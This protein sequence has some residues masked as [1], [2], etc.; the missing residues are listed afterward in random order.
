MNAEVCQTCAQNSIS[1]LP[2][3][4]FYCKPIE[5]RFLPHF[6]IPRKKLSLASVL[7]VFFLVA[8]LQ[9]TFNSFLLRQNTRYINI[10]SKELLLVDCIFAAFFTI[11]TS[12]WSFEWNMKK[13]HFFRSLFDC[14]LCVWV[15][16]LVK[17]Q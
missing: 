5:C 9:L 1:A 16:V 8:W 7:G 10:E 14:R 6:R 15:R 13:M 2:H 17:F 4:N 3:S 11:L 12:K